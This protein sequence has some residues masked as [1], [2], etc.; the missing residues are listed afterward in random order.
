MFF[1]FGSRRATTLGPRESLVMRLMLDRPPGNRYPDN[2]RTATASSTR[3]E[4]VT[5]CY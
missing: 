5:V 3:T 2:D 4:T 1:Q